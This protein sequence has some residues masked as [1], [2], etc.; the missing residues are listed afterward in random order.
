MLPLQPGGTFHIYTHANGRD[1]LFSETK[2]YHY[3][4]E[5]YKL[6]IPPIAYIQLATALCPITCI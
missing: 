1:N 6:H 5:K 4:L 2:N 3:F